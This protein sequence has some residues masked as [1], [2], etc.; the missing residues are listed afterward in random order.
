[1]STVEFS[2][3]ADGSFIFTIRAGDLMV[4]VSFEDVSGSA[5]ESWERLAAG[6]AAL[7]FCPSNGTVGLGVKDDTA[8]FEVAKYGAGG[9]G[10]ITVSVPLAAARPAL[11][12]AADHRRSYPDRD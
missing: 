7:D 2:T 4:E 9:D 10:C 1:M 8:H 6:S 12:A 3:S 11:L 5:P